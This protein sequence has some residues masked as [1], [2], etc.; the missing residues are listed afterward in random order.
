MRKARSW[1]CWPTFYRG[2]QPM[3]IAQPS[4]FLLPFTGVRPMCTAHPQWH[5][6]AV[7]WRQRVAD[8][9][10]WWVSQRWE[11]G[12][13]GL[14]KHHAASPSSGPRTKQ[15]LPAAYF[16]DQRAD[17]CV[18]IWKSNATCFYDQGAGVCVCVCAGS[19]TA[20]WIKERGW[21]RTP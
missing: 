9:A 13:Q 16:S 5:R 4:P 14:E 12:R 10:R 1:H 7:Y 18:C 11:P 20:L 15:Q 3:R 8:A 17:V 6:P 2:L 19:L 21:N